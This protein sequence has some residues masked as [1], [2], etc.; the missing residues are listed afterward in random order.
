MI[1]W[2]SHLKLQLPPHMQIQFHI[3]QMTK[4]N[5]FALEKSIKIELMGIYEPRQNSQID[6]TSNLLRIEM[7]QCKKMGRSCIMLSLIKKV[8]GYNLDNVY[9]V[10]H[11][12]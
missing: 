12:Y 3:D 2:P 11:W 10:I 8:N 7:K 6:L 9:N 1:V 4:M 5:G